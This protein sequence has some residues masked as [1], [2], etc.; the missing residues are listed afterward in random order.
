MTTKPSDLGRFAVDGSDVDA[1]NISAPTSGLRDTG[2]T[3]NYIPPAAEFNYLENVAYRWRQYLDDGDFTG[4]VSV[5]TLT[6]TGN[7]TFGGNFDVVGTLKV[8]R[9]VEIG[10]QPAIVAD[11]V[12]TA[13]NATEVFTATSHGLATGDGPFQVSNSGGALPG[14]L[15][16]ATDYWI[17]RLNSSTFKLATSLAN[18]LTETNLLI[19]TDGT[20][21]QTLSD[22]VST[23]RFADVHIFGA[24]NIEKGISIGGTFQSGD[25]TIFGDLTV[26]NVTATHYNTPST[27][28]IFPAVAFKATDG[29]PTYDANGFWEF[30]NGVSDTVACELVIPIGSRITKMAFH[31]N[32]ASASS[33]SFTCSLNSKTVGG[34]TYF[35]GTTTGV[36]FDTLTTGTG[37]VSRDIMVLGGNTPFTFVAGDTYLMEVTGVLNYAGAVPAFDGVEVSYGQV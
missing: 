11:I 7:T 2:F 22:T 19:S 30:G 1:T 4:G 20:G 9:D 5:D 8:G 33:G 14:G 25:A 18:A 32:R 27:P 12:F 31:V 29:T 13:N 16:V 23:E 17:I 28:L 26:V 36:Y 35:F 24:C 37:W 21:T 6:V 10:G 3:D 34:G 15:T